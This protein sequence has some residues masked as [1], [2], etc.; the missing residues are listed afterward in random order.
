MNSFSYCVH[1]RVQRATPT[2]GGRVILQGTS[3]KKIQSEPERVAGL[4]RGRVRL[5]GQRLLVPE[6]VE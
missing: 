5:R 4:V 3:M 2:R 1:G 6:E